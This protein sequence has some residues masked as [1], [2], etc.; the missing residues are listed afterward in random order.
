MAKTDI[1][2]DEQDFAEANL[3]DAGLSPAELYREAQNL[4]FH[5]LAELAGFGDIP[6]ELDN[7][8]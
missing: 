1:I 5:R 2:P 4:K 8:N 3:I 7:P 6:G